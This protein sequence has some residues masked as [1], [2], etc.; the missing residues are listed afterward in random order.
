M[1]YQVL[2]KQIRNG[3]DPKTAEWIESGDC[4]ETRSM[5][6][7][8]AEVTARDFR[9][10]CKVVTVAETPE[11]G[12]QYPLITDKVLAYFGPE[13]HAVGVDYFS[14]LCDGSQYR[15]D[16]AGSKYEVFKPRVQGW[17]TFHTFELTEAI[18]TEFYKAERVARYGR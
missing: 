10:P 5:A 7:A 2:V 12:V 3:S 14:F 13:E 9:V 8:F 18:R 6:M 1:K 16:A 15:T 11:E 17:V 4:V